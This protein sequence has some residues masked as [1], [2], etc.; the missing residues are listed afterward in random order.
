MARKKNIKSTQKIL[1]GTDLNQ[2][3][4]WDTKVIDTTNDNDI[5]DP[6]MESDSMDSTTEIIDDTNDTAGEWTLMTWDDLQ[7]DT[8]IS[9]VYVEAY[10]WEISDDAYAKPNILAQDGDISLSEKRRQVRAKKRIQL[11]GAITTIALLV[12]IFVIV[13]SMMKL[14]LFTH[15]IIKEIEVPVDNVIEVKEEVLKNQFFLTWDLNI[16]YNIPNIWEWASRVRD[17]M[18]YNDL[19]KKQYDIKISYRD[20]IKNEKLWWNDILITSDYN[21]IVLR[22]AN[23]QDGVS[24]SKISPGKSV[25]QITDIIF[26]N[27]DDFTLDVIQIWNIKIPDGISTT[28]NELLNIVLSNS[29]F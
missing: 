17:V 24:D 20:F 9:K 25:Y 15:I 12:S 10:D 11:L 4:M 2:N 14:P 22:I 28:K 21:D 16:R 5:Q 18:F 3:H 29:I 6:T 26:S 27:I 8:N 7:S 1:D 23:L 19:T 13:W